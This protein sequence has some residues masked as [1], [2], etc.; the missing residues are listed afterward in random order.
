MILTAEQFLDVRFV[1]SEKKLRLAFEKKPTLSVCFVLDFDDARTR[2]SMLFCKGKS[3][4]C[5]HLGAIVIVSPR[6]GVAEPDCRKQGQLSFGRTTI[7]RRDFDQNIFDARFC[8]FGNNVEI[9]VFVERARFEEFVL[10]VVL[11]P[12]AVFFYQ[13]AVGEFALRIFVQALHIR[14]GR[15][16]IEIEVVLLDVFAVIAFV[17][18]EAEQPFLQNWIFAIPHR[19][20]KTNK[21]AAV[22]NPH[23]SVF[24]PTIRSRTRVVMRK[25]IP[26]CAVLAVIFT[27]GAPLA[28]GK[29]GTPTP[30]V[31]LSI[32]RFFQAFFFGVHRLVSFKA[33][34]NFI[35]LRFQSRVRPDLE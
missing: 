33:F 16:G 19:Q 23:D 12:P 25:E 18:G 5:A 10:V 6:P 11:S 15:R 24:A 21:L 30:P 26:G 22:G 27:H 9:S 31:R 13:L 28:L 34:G 32:P 29:I 14:V 1:L 8:V 20:G 17:A 7:A 4:R 35:R 2:G 3:F